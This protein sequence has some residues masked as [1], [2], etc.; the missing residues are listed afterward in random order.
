MMR[1]RM[2]ILT[3][4]ILTILMPRAHADEKGGVSDGAQAH[5]ESVAEADSVLD[6]TM[7]DID[8]NPTNLGEKY[9]GKV[10]LVVN[11][12]SKCGL[13]PQ[14]ADLESMYEKYRGQGF[15][16][17]AF[18]SNDFGGQEPGTEKEIKEF[19]SSNYQVTFPLFS[20]IP[21]KGENKHPLYAYLTDSEKNSATGGEITWNFTKFLVGRDGKIIARFEPKTKPTEE[22]VAQAVEKALNEKAPDQEG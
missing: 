17:L 2:L 19:C 12:A 22:E 1:I 18:P 7:K 5:E 9:A 20:K 6:F 14:Y 13:T 3:T 16:I 15:E 21:V 11:T 10:L 4:A 8:G